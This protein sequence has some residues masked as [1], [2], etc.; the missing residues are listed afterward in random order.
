MNRLILSIYLLFMFISCEKEPEKVGMLEFDIESNQFSFEGYA[1]RYNDFVNDK[2]IGYDW[3]VFNLG[4]NALYIQVYDSTFTKLVFP[5]PAFLAKYT[6]ELPGGQSKTYQSTGGQ[7]RL[8]G[9]KEGDAT[10]DFHF[11]MKNILD[12]TDSILIENGYFRIWLQ[13]YDRKFY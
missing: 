11:K 4:Q 6:Y 3:H 9:P 1:Y 10:G 13:K 8:L 12:P 5:Y 7:F 2:G